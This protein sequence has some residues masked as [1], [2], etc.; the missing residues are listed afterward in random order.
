MA[1]TPLQEHT[2][3]E[4]WL[5]RDWREKTALAYDLSEPKRP[6]QEADDDILAAET[7]TASA[8]ARGYS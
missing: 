8:Q 1:M 2:R 5:A 4:C 3:G 6:T 7:R